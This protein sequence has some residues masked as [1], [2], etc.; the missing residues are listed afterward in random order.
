MAELFAYIQGPMIGSESGVGDIRSD[1]LTYYQMNT[2][3]YVANRETP[4]KNFGMHKLEFDQTPSRKALEDRIIEELGKI[5]EDGVIGGGM[6]IP[7]HQININIK[8]NN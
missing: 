1:I 4:I 3:V 5:L 7:T 2:Q 6:I 8:Y